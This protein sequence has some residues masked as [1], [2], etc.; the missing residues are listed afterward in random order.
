MKI[1]VIIKCRATISRAF[2][3]N[4]FTINGS[5]SS[6]AL[7]LDHGHKDQSEKTRKRKNTD[8]VQSSLTNVNK[9][10]SWAVYNKNL[11][12]EE[13][14]KALVKAANSISEQLKRGNQQGDW[15][16]KEVND[17]DSL[18]FR[19]LVPRFKRLSGN[20]K[21]ILHFADNIPNEFSIVLLARECL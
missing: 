17:E 18:F 13:V 4:M 11:S 8:N 10:R 5:S 1:F 20:Q 19:S 2:H 12:K 14:D 16:E 9:S 15:G 7:A 3:A 6:S 21:V